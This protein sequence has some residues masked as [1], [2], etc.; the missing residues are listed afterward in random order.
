MGKNRWDEALTLLSPH[1]YALVS[2]IDKNGKPNLMGVAWWS[3]VSW[4]PQMIGIAVGKRRYT[5]ECLNSCKE[6]V[7]LFPSH[8]VA[9]GA[10]LCGLES[11]RDIDKWEKGGFRKVKAKNVKPYLFEG[12]T[13]A[14]ECKV[15]KEIECGDHIFYVGDV[16]EIH[17]DKA[18]AMHLYT[19]HYRRLVAVDKDLNTM[20][21]FGLER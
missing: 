17:T 6:F 1:P 21:D 12:F 8:K 16:V 7:L 10:W 9:K 11:G 3:I 2:T 15:T 19:V 5:K 14:F 20:S 13:V 4:D 18:N